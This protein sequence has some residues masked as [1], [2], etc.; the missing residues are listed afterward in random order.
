METEN[1]HQQNGGAPRNGPANGSVKFTPLHIE[2]MIHY[3]AVNEPLKQASAPAVISFTADLI[4]LGV[5]REDKDS[6][7]GYSATDKGSAWVDK[8][9]S[10]PLPVQQWI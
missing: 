9:C 10:T 4:E 5:I 1:K 6:G 3:Y 2:L 7:S 8:I